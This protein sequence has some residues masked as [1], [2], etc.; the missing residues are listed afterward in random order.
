[1]KDMRTGE[2]L[3]LDKKE[4]FGEISTHTDVGDSTKPI[5]DKEK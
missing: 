3:L 5:L 4:V 2:Q 1:M